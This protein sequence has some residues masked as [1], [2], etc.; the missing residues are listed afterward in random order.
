MT[1]LGL[2]VKKVKKLLAKGGS[3]WETSLHKVQV[4][5]IHNLKQNMANEFFSMFTKNGCKPN[6]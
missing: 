4:R 3:S 5:C 2:I 1:K 6:S